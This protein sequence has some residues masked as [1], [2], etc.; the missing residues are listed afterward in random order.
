MEVKPGKKKIVLTSVNQILTLVRANEKLQA[1]PRFKNMSTYELSTTPV[2]SCN[3]ARPIQ[4]PDVNKQV[5]E[6]TLS[7][8]TAKDFLEVKNALG[9]DELC[10]YNRN[11]ETNKLEMICV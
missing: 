7:A 1:L 10:Y 5:V 3:C 2:K 11:R 6:K 4:T 9:L 8:L